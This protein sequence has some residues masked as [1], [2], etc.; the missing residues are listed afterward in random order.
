MAYTDNPARVQPVPLLPG[1]VGQEGGGM[2]RFILKR[3]Q[4]HDLSGGKTERLWSIDH[5]LVAL[6]QAL[7]AGGHSQQAYDFNELVGVELV[8]D[9]GPATPPENSARR[10]EV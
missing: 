4:M 6:E 1:R 2:I 8:G 3:K 5:D 7:R 10:V 9:M